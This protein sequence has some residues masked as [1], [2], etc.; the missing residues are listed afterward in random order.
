MKIDAYIA[1]GEKIHHAERIMVVSH[2]RPDGDAIGSLLGLGL[3]LQATGKEVQLVSPDGVPENFRHLSG[4]DQI[5]QYPSEAFDLIVVLDCSDLNRVGHVLDDYTIPDINIDHHITNLSFGR[6]NIVDTEAV[7][8]AEILVEALNFLEIPLTHDCISALLTGIIMD[9]LGFRTHNITPRAMR[10]VATLMESGANLP[11]LYTKAL[12]QRSFEA[13]RFW[14][15]GLMHIEREGAFVWTSLSIA[16]REVAGYSGRDDADLINV[17]TTIKDAKVALI[18]V[19]QPHGRVKVSWRSQPGI[20]VS[21]VAVRFGGGGHPA[22]SGA[23]IPGSMDEIKL[24]V[25]EE[26]R[27]L[28]AEVKV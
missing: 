25:L 2:I 4:S 11:E 8:T 16:D 12:M 3:A 24:V 20:D 10:V 28:I 18:F 23:V 21:Q 13:V 7:A 22:A 27:N 1:L 17:L 15:E 5:I 6:L 14:G 19:E 9:T 26:T